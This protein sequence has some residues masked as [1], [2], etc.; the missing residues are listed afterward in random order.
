MAKSFTLLYLNDSLDY[1]EANIV[2]ID[3]LLEDID[4]NLNN[5]FETVEI[6]AS[7]ELVSKTM[8]LIKKGS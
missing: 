6:K 4:T 8:T 1:P 3:K 7:S 5:F 2:E